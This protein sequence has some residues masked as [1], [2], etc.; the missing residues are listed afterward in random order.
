MILMRRRKTLILGFV[1]AAILTPTAVLCTSFIPAFRSIPWTLSYLVIAFVAE[2][3]G[4]LPALLSGVISLC[5][6]YSLVLAPLQTSFHEPKLWLQGGAFIITAGFI[7]Y[8]VRQRS[9][10]SVAQ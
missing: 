4:V 7:T 6:V 10:A 8:L 3:G 5:S 2:I 1:S 9:L